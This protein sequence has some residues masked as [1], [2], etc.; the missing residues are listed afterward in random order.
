VR[1]L[2]ISGVTMLYE[3]PRTHDRFLA[4]D[5]VSMTV[6]EA[7]FVSIVGPSGC[8]KSTLL[9]IVDG[10][11]R[12]SSG[13]V[14]VGGKEVTGPGPDRGM[15]FQEASLLPWYTTLQNCAYGLQCQG[16]PAKEARQRALPLLEMVGLKGF[17]RSFPG[18][19]SIGMQQRA[20]VARALAVEPD[21]LL[22][23][24]PFAALDAQ[25][26]EVMQAELLRIWDQTRKTVLFITHQLDEAIYLSDRVIVMSGRP[27]RI[28]DEITIPIGRPR[29]L[30]VKRTPTFAKLE[31]RI[32]DDLR[33]DIEPGRV[34]LAGKGE[35]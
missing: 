5:G 29:S 4:L 31:Q 25:T 19:L 13:S 20:N 33:G 2:E 21:V 8:G 15:V 12:Q 22:M 26:R 32:W 1:S 34:P 18:E 17:E 35:S 6:E 9:S 7:S 23:D 11:I 27:G 10:L 24:E 16:V 3:R 14:R 28:I 30:D